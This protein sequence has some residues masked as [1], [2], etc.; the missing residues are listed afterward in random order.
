MEENERFRNG[1]ELDENGSFQTHF[2]LFVISIVASESFPPLNQEAKVVLRTASLFILFSLPLMFSLAVWCR[3]H[4][5][6]DFSY[7]SLSSLIFFDLHDSSSFSCSCFILSSWLFFC[8]CS[9]S[10]FEYCI[11]LCFCTR[12]CFHI[13]YCCCFTVALTTNLPISL[14]FFL[15][16]LIQ[17]FSNHRVNG[18]M[19]LGLL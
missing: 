3:F 12:Y 4:S 6:F 19:L 14:F 7:L 5:H 8:S 15:N 13:L 18:F 10:Y 11:C 9:H 2:F 16:L 17:T 1:F